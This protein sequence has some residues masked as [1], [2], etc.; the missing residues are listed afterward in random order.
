MYVGTSIKCVASRKVSQKSRSSICLSADA[1]DDAS[2]FLE[3]EKGMTR[4]ILALL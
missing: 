4:G 2:N 1:D 3:G